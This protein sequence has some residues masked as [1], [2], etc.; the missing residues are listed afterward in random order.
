MMARRKHTEGFTFVEMMIVL[1]ILSVMIIMAVPKTK[2]KIG[3]S[4]DQL[5]HEII[6]TQYS[7]IITDGRKRFTDRKL[8]TD[9]HFNRRGNPSCAL[10]IY[11]GDAR[12][13]V[14]LG[15]GRCYEWGK[16]ICDD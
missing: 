16:W 11:L 13:I 12:I 14:S 5:I 6:M 8:D 4:S 10:S 7:A 9:F 15:T 1:L 2:G 3:Q